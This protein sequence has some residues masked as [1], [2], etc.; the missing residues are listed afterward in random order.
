MAAVSLSAA[1]VAAAPTALAPPILTA[2]ALYMG[3][4]FG[5]LS[6]PDNP[7]DF[8]SS[9]ISDMASH[10]LAPTGLC[11]AVCTPLG[12]YTP[13]KI[14]LV[15]GFG[16]LTFDDSVAQG[17]FNLDSCVRGLPCVSTPP[18]YTSTST[19]RLTDT[20]YTV[21]GYSQ[22]ATV[23]TNEK[24]KLMSD[25]ASASISFVLVANPNRPNGGI[26]ERFT[27]S[28]IPFLGITFNG[29]TPTDSAQS[30]PLTTVDI[31]G[32]YDLM[33]DFPTNPLNLLA[34][35]N[36][37]I[38]YWTVHQQPFAGGAPELQGR[39][40]DST[41]YLI[42][43]PTL[44]LLW[45][46][47]QIPYAGPFVTAL[48]DPPLRVL[49]ESG[50]DRLINPGAPTPANWLYFQNPISTAI[51]LLQSIPTGWDNAIAYATGD[52]ANR[53]LGT[54]PPSTYGV[55]GP[56][57][58]AGAVDAYG[59]PTPFTSTTSIQSAA[60]SSAQEPDQEPAPQRGDPAPSI[61]A[62]VASA[63]SA[64][65]E[66]TAA[67]AEPSTTEKTT[68][69]KTSTEKPSTEETDGDKFPASP[70]DCTHAGKLR[71]FSAWVQSRRTGTGASPA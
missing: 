23:A 12:V 55:G 15:T 60:T 3:G 66:S 40:Q 42:P 50:Y 10:Y 29:A 32:Q 7:P 20:S 36:A 47:A 5:Q 19:T 49:V 46:V 17:M 11:A 51:N 52:S 61:T 6:V 56:P 16:D 22:S 13:E 44:P 34:D 27:G 31:A 43:T 9:Y 38:G 71:P 64:Q 59:D 24:A 45:P 28:Y 63:A 26:L 68:T 2:T 8:I 35:L 67:T 58:K 25:P 62:T 33:S 37:L 18:P 53:P 48:L 65:T 41:Y 54:T 14:R 30:A 70:R 4:T 21:L 69:R 57:V 1:L 39:Y